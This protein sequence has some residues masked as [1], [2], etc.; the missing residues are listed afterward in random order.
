M[1]RKMVTEFGMSERI[2]HITLG[3][4]EGPIFLGRDIV[5]HKNYSE[6]TA[7]LID[8]EVKRIVE[9][10]YVKVKNILSENI[11]KVRMIAQRLLEKEVLDAQE[12]KEIIG[13][14]AADSTSQQNTRGT[15]A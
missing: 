1:A 13:F 11:E 8:E 10:V 14:K 4:K 2:G 6:E 15:S 7:K 5:E 12:V 3:R 9:D